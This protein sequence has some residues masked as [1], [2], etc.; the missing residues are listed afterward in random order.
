MR[1]VAAPRSTGFTPEERAAMKERAQELKAV[2]GAKKG[3]G[4]RDVFAKIAEMPGPDRAMEE[5][6]HAIVQASAPASQVA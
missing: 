2:A 5:R 4:E 1:A 3:D 6:I